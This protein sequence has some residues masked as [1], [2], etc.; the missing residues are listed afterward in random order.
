MWSDCNLVHR[1]SSGIHPAGDGFHKPNDLLEGLAAAVENLLKDGEAP[2]GVL[3]MG[4][5]S[6]HDD[7]V[8]F[9]DAKDAIV[10]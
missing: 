10:N 7:I 2:G 8:A 1:N 6:S 3:T 4:G 9:R 5:F